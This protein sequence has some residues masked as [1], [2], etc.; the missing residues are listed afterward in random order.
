M[1]A[2]ETHQCKQSLQHHTHPRILLCPGRRTRWLR[3]W[4]ACCP[5][6]TE[7]RGS[8]AKLSL[9]L[10][11]YI[12]D[13]DKEAQSCHLLQDQAQEDIAHRGAADEQNKSSQNTWPW[14]GT[15]ARREDPRKA[16]V[17]AAMMIVCS[18]L[19]RS[20]SEGLNTGRK[21][22]FRRRV[23]SLQRQIRN[24]QRAN[25]VDRTG[26]GAITRRPQALQHKAPRFRVVRYV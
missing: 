10:N 23:T 11:K 15:A 22:Y 18:E 13:I 16:L 1:C 2:S 4:S 17:T 24:V 6:I 8:A 14:V 20:K 9:L 3:V 21:I 19:Y 5:A 26:F 7:N 25:Q 12:A